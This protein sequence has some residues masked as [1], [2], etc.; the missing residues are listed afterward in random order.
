[1][2]L[3]NIKLFENLSNTEKKNLSLLVQ[4]KKL[5]T[6]ELL[7]KQWDEANSMY[8]LVEGELEVFI[9]K[10][11]EKIIL[12]KVRAEEIIWEMA[13]FWNKKKRMASA[14]TIKDSR[15]LVIL[16]FSI[17]QIAEKYPKLLEK[18]KDIIKQR[19]EENRTKINM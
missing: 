10:S 12:W 16:E 4:E 7:F 6:W 17:K 3:D 8:F 1:M 19:E 13:I 15:L 2:N 14:I 5:K 18:I 9:E 11:W